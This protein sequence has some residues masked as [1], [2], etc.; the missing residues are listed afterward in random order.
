[1]DEVKKW[2]V[3]STATL[4]ISVWVT[5]FFLLVGQK[6][7]MIATNQT[8][9]THSKE[10]LPVD[11]QFVRFE[12]VKS[13]STDTKRQNQLSKEKQSNSIIMYDFEKENP[14]S[15]DT[16]LAELNIK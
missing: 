6:E 15:I 5:F 7:P 16:L 12:I 1:M 11:Q 10:K 13:K 2:I 9:I 14:V 4:A 3:V 8:N